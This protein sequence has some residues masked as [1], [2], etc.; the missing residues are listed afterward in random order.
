M[1]DLKKLW[2]DDVRPLPKEYKDSGEWTIARTAWEALFKLEI[3]D[4]EEVSLD[5]D[6]AS[7]VGNREITGYDI[8]N[9]LVDRKVHKQ[10]VPKK[11]SVHSANPVGVRQMNATIQ[12]YW[13]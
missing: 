4:I 13:R 6:L 9:W 5:H 3:M 8:L 2:I 12:R 10:P 7:F 1:C 11:V